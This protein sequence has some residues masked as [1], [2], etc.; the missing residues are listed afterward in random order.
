MGVTYIKKKIDSWSPPESYDGYK[1]LGKPYF[2]HLLEKIQGQIN[3]AMKSAS[4][5]GPIA[6]AV[7]R[8][9]LFN[10]DSWVQSVDPAAVPW[11]RV[12]G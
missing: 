4:Q 2:S 12:F 9:D 1:T 7:G 8:Y 5:P 11:R 3:A 6:S 10:E